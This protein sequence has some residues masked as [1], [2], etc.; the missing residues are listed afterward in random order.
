MF[1][2]LVKSSRKNIFYPIKNEEYRIF[3][4]KN[5]LNDWVKT[6]CLCE[7]EN[8]KEI[9]VSNFDRHNVS[10]KTVICT[11]CGLMRAKNYLNN[12][13]LRNFYKYHYRRLTTKLSPKKKFE[14]QYQTSKRKG[15]YALIEKYIDLNNKVIFDIG[16]ASGG[17]LHPYIKKIA[18]LFLIM[19]SSIQ[20]M[21]NKGVL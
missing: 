7:G 19:M 3:F 6:Q 15:R 2:R 12:D 20:I 13:A 18:A 4:E 17:F 1:K 21:R 9:L 10:F 16:G 11:N 8:N 14:Q 5:Y